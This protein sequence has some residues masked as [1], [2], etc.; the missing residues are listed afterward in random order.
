MDILEV[1]ADSAASWALHN[2][3]LSDGGLAVDTE[4][5][6]MRIGDGRTP[7]SELAD[8]TQPSHTAA[9]YLAEASRQYE[10]TPWYP[11]QLKAYRHAEFSRMAQV[12]APLLHL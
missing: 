10:E 7:W 11:E 5:G 2:P 12:L 4:S 9:R 3:V 6:S 1:R 8:D